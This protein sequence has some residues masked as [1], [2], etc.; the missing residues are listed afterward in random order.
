MI[1]YLA[2]LPRS[3]ST[4]LASVLNQ[5][6]E[7]F[8]SSS[9][10]VCNMLYHSHQLWQT[11]IA[12]QANPNPLAVHNAMSA[13]VPSFY[14]DR[15]ERLIVDKAFTW[16]LPDNLS[17]LLQYSPNKPKFIVMTRNLDD[18]IKSLAT[19][20]YENPDNVFDSG[21]TDERTIENVKTYICRPSGVIQRCIESR[22]TLLAQCPDSCFVVQYERLVSSPNELIQELYDFFEIPKYSHRFDKIE[23]SNTDNDLVWGLPTMHEIKGSL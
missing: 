20:V 21:M 19:L 17:L 11:Q 18:V 9:S 10:P 14:S 3:G 7:V 2:G 12:L 6:P 22:N 16:G 13:I 8:V 23:N 4:V 5:N 1:S 15:T